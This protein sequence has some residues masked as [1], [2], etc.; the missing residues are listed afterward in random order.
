DPCAS[1]ARVFGDEGELP[2]PNGSFVGRELASDHVGSLIGFDADDA[3]PVEC[4]LSPADDLAAERERLRRPERAVRA[5]P[6]GGREYLF[7]GHVRDILDSRRGA[8]WVADPQGVAE[9]SD[10]E[11]RAGA[12]VTQRIWPKLVQRRGAPLELGE[13]LAPG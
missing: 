8:H 4:E 9:Q 12:A 10:R 1:D 7:G 2:E 6:V 5:V 3:T 11:I 13:V